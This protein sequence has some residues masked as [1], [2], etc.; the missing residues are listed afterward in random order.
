MTEADYAKLKARWLKE[1]GG[2]DNAH[3]VQPILPLP[4]RTR[5]RLAIHHRVNAAGIW[6]VERGRYRAATVLWRVC[7]RL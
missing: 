4:A 7:R 1:H 6:L 3:R 5:A 2:R